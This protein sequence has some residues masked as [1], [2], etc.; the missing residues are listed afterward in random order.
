VGQMSESDGKSA[1]FVDGFV[2]GRKYER[3]IQ[4]TE[5]VEPWHG[6]AQSDLCG[7]PGQ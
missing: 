1:D 6:K 4:N 3:L 7:I 5:R 2:A